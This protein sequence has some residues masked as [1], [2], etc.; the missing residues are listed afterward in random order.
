MFAKGFF[1]T[2]AGR[3]FCAEPDLS[4]VVDLPLAAV[5]DAGMGLRRTGPRLREAPTIAPAAAPSGPA[6]TPPMTAPATAR[7]TRRRRLLL[8]AVCVSSPATTAARLRFLVFMID[9]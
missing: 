4:V 2:P 9:F 8:T 7:T 1:G 3:R 6:M 5:L